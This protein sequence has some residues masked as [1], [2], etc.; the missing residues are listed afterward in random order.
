MP[1]E[2]TAQELEEK[3]QV[4]ANDAAKFGKE[5]AEVQG[6]AKSCEDRKADYLAELT[7]KA[8]GASIAEKE[9]NARVLP[10]WIEFRKDLSRMLSE[11]LKLR[12]QY[13]TSVRCWDTARSLL[14]SRNAE[15]RTST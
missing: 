9:R 1:R 10:E 8:E 11:A 12:I 3:L 14:S 13:E 2:F 6:V 7:L 4:F 15:R 5:W